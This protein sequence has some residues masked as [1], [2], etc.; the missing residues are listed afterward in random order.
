MDSHPG[1]VPLQVAGQAISKSSH[2]R[3]KLG[4]GVI[5]LKEE[6]FFPLQI[7]IISHLKFHLSL[8]FL[9]G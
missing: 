4:V 7:G 9:K 8:T 6:H 2:V 1:R 5:F 3:N